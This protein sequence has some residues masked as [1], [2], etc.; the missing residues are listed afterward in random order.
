MKRIQLTRG[1][2]ALV[3]DDLFDELSQYEWRA[4]QAGGYTYYAYRNENRDGVYRSV[5]MHRHIYSHL[6]LPT[7]DCI[8]HIDGNG[9]NNQ[10]ANLRPAT[11]AEN[12]R[13]QRLARSNRSGYRGVCWATK[14]QK[15]IAAISVDNRRINLGAFDS[16]V[17]A[18]AAYDAAAVKYHGEFARPNFSK[19][20]AVA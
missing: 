1:K 7:K 10:T 11:F 16:K 12:S 18:A 3:D 14:R 15:W 8:D 6:N 17:D 5:S 4:S 20:S 19:P 13:N 2:F 9:L